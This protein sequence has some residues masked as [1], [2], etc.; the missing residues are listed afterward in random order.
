[1]P[2]GIPGYEILEEL[3][4]G[5]MG[6]VYRARQRSLNRIVALK[7]LLGPGSGEGLE[8]FKVEAEAIGQLPQQLG[9][10][11]HHGNGQQGGDQ[12]GKLDGRGRQGLAILELLGRGPE[13][14]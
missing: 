7:M 3:G 9:H 10:R 4:R 2:A 14:G 12:G 1:M 5:G 11:D 13:P 8:R 6:V